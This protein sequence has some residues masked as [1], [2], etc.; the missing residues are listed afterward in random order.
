MDPT[1]SLA[2]A[3]L[4]GFLEGEPVLWLSTV[5]ADGAP[6]LVPTW[7][8]WDGREIVIVSKP[9]AR[10]ARN[11]A[12]DPRVM[13]ALG[14]AEDDFDVGMLE[15]HGWLDPA[16]TPAE[17][18][19]GFA[20]KY[21]DRIAELGLTT[22]QF[23]ATYSQ[24]IR[25]VPSRALGWHGRSRPTSVVMAAR[26]VAASGAIS[27]D[28]PRAERPGLRAWLGEPLARGFRGLGR[29]ALAGMRP[30]Y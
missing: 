25:I 7:F 2:D 5:S 19:T 12:T 24:V 23:A 18:P 30:A 4:T 16:P 15:A 14:D 1:T 20:A 21:A 13:I 27:I 26:A 8:V 3:R 29:P 9:G 10:K 28:E 11:L 17:L 22:A 6:H